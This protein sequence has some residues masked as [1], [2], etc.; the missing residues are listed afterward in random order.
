MPALCLALVISACGDTNKTP[1]SVARMRSWN[2]EQTAHETR[3]AFI[4]KGAYIIGLKNNADFQV[5]Q[6]VRLIP[7]STWP[8]QESK[9]TLLI[10]RIAERQKTAAR[11]EIL[12]FQP[13]MREIRPDFQ[14]Y[15]IQDNPAQTLH[16][17]TKRMTF[18]AGKA[19]KDVV[20]TPMNRESLIQGN[21]IYG[22]F[23]L[24]TAHQN[25][26]LAN[27]NMA[28]LQ[29]DNSTDEETHLV[30][31]AGMIPDSAA[32]VLLD[33]PMP[34]AFDINI[35]IDEINGRN[36]IID[37]LNQILGQ[38]IPGAEFIHVRPETHQPD[39]DKTLSM[40]G[41][42]QTETLDIVLTAEKKTPIILDQAL[43][44]TDSPFT[45]VLSENDPKLAANSLAARA[46]EMLGYPSSAAFILEN[47]WT[48]SNSVQTWA[49]LAPA[50]ASLYHRMDR[51]DWALEIGLEMLE[52]SKS[53]SKSAKAQAQAAAATAFAISGRS[54]EFPDVFDSVHK[55]LSS[56]SVP[57]RKTFAHAMLMSQDLPKWH[58]YF[59]EARKSWNE[60]D[61]MAECFQSEDNDT[62]QDGLDKS[63]TEIGRLWFLSMLN[64]YREPSTKQI[65]LA[66]KIDSIGAPNLAVHH[67]MNMISA[68]LNAEASSSAWINMARYARRSQQI[69]AFLRDMYSY[70]IHQKSFD[71]E[72]FGDS[73][74]G[75][76]SLDWRAELAHSCVL[77]SATA[78]SGESI[79][80]LEL[81]S[82]LYISIGDAE[83][84]AI[85]SAK[86][87]RIYAQMN[88]MEKADFYRIKAQSFAANTHHKEVL[89]A[90]QGDAAS[91]EE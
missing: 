31:K 18:A 26:R 64:A 28:L 75:W 48:E 87:S 8:E 14:A 91:A 63:Q 36:E 3:V 7:G 23:D 17:I 84:A 32:F 60:F 56:L 42:T 33:A 22:A 39:I 20:I 77:R 38:S 73:I 11:I 2:F 13:G 65:E 15:P 29:A 16:S 81:A 66:Q 40:L 54:S 72:I 46:F 5:N 80:L 62:C 27:A 89:K 83:N 59:A 58:E 85:V 19:S 21:E 71:A 6:W 88:Q 45:A 69:R 50:L 1:E 70:A 35:Q 90:I 9:P 47:A 34:P 74:Y 78:T 57:W 49:S 82:E 37:H 61:E 10:G 51:D 52:L 86:L 55:S 79:D 53:Q 76:K 12:A 44:V 41:K 68:G 43:R 25:R 67:W 30:R 24:S 4:P